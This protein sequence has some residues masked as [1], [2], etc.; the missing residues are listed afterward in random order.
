MGLSLNRMTSRVSGWF[1]QLWDRCPHQCHRIVGDQCP[2]KKTM[3]LSASKLPFWIKYLVCQHQAYVC[4]LQQEVFSCYQ[5][6]NICIW[7]I[8]R[9]RH[10]FFIYLPYK[11]GFYL[12]TTLIATVVMLWCCDCSRASLYKSG[13]TQFVKTRYRK[14][15]DTLL[16]K[17]QLSS[18]ITRCLDFEPR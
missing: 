9:H 13:L 11:S 14:V 6:A 1:R 12:T 2:T 17:P 8:Y 4:S 16:I 3:R 18:F 7:S 5:T 10:E 15:V